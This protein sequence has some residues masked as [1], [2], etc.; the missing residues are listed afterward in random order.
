MT[1][2]AGGQRKSMLVARHIHAQADDVAFARRNVLGR[3]DVEQ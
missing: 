2:V 3:L 1:S